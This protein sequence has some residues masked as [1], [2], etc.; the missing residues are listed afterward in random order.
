MTATEPMVGEEHRLSGSATDEDGILRVKSNA[1]VRPLAQAIA[2]QVCSGKHV[3]LRAVGAGA[4]GQAVKAL[5]VARGFTAPVG[6]DIAV[7]PAFDT[8]EGVRGDTISAIT[9][10]VVRLT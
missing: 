9:F 7:V 2:A 6:I 1:A 5:A 10:R 4:V 3:V 8:I